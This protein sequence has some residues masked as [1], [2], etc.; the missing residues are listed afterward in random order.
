MRLFLAF[1]VLGGT[2]LAF[3]GGLYVAARAMRPIAGLTRAAREVARTRDP[4]I[5]LPK[6]RANDEVSDLA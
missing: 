6:P 4:D 5:T 3:L 2:L 1:G